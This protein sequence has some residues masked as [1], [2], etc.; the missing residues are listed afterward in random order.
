MV[1]DTTLKIMASR[2][3]SMARN[4]YLISQKSTIIY[5]VYGRDKYADWMMIT[6][7]YTFPL[8]R[9]ID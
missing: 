5:K 3:P 7:T 1:A 8:G 2:S 4:P 6:L 9:E